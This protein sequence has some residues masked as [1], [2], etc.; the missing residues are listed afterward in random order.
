MAE[1]QT[2]H[3][4][5]LG[6][7]A[8]PKKN[9]FQALVE[10]ARQHPG[11]YIGAVA[12]VVVVLIATGVYRSM[13]ASTLR[14][15]STVYVEAIETESAADRATAL[16]QLAESKS[17]F[18]ARA[19]YLEGEAALDAGEY[20]RARAAFTDLRE[21]FPEFAF[22]P[23]AVEGIGF[24]EEDAGDYA[25]ARKTY[26]EVA[27]KWPDSVAA[28]RQPF[29][30][31]RCYESESD[32]VSA[33]AQYRAQLEKFPGSTIAVRAQERL[34]ELRMSNPDLF[35]DEQT[36]AGESPVLQ[37]LTTAPAEAPGSVGEALDEAEAQDAPPAA[38][39][40]G[41]LLPQ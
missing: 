5:H 16:T 21:R 15:E 29:N 4:K 35:A 2:K 31:G 33:I 12:F 7:E 39:A 22:V 27:A 41:D 10:H 3:S 9:D 14:K 19:L 28:M 8:E 13:Q 11:I 40:P 32:L 20:D 30:L 6:D 34:N 18:A 1:T 17:S 37:E 38:E 26:E 25:A 24:I 23:E 36:A